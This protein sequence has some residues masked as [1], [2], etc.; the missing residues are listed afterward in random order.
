MM[1]LIGLYVDAEY[2]TSD[3]RI[4]I[5]LQTDRFIYIIELKSDHTAEAALRQID[6][7]HYELP[8]V[9]DGR[10]II[11]IGVNFSTKMR[12]IKDWLIKD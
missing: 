9:C 3:G 7:K 1:K 11:K 4:D 10:K 12:T 2:R 5:L 8:F 6:N